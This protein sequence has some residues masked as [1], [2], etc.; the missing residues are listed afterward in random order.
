MHLCTNSATPYTSRQHMRSCNYVN[1]SYANRRSR[2]TT[3]VAGHEK[4]RWLR[5][6]QEDCTFPKLHIACSHGKPNHS[7]MPAK[8]HP[9]VVVTEAEPGHAQHQR[10]RSA[11]PSTRVWMW[12]RLFAQWR[13][14]KALHVNALHCSARM[15]ELLPAAP[16]PK[17]NGLSHHIQVG[18]VA[19][20]CMSISSQHSTP[21][22]L[23]NQA[24]R[25]HQAL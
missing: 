2:L 16:S 19:H 15:Q 3:A 24:S 12:S 25:V 4:S 1:G 13:G 17:Q 9:E 5:H 21:I 20:M 22:H 8:F 11:Q 23:R 10:M 14:A 18:R 6:P 7:L